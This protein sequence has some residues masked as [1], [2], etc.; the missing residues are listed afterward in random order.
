M[1][2]KA[3]RQLP[4]PRRKDAVQMFR[5]VSTLCV[6]MLVLSLLLSSCVSTFR[7]S[8]QFSDLDE[9]R[10]KRFNEEFMGTKYVWGGTSKSGVD[11]S[12]FTSLAYQD[13][14]VILPRTSSQQY[15]IGKPVSSSDLQ[16]GDLLFFNT[17]GRGVSHVGI[18]VEPGKMVHASTSQGVTRT[19]F[20]S[21]Y[22][23]KRYIGARR[24][25]GSRFT[26]GELPDER[27]LISSYYPMTVRSLV[28]TP[29]PYTQLHRHYTLEFMT[30]RLG[31]LQFETQFGLWNRLEI[32]AQATFEQVLGEGDFSVDMPTLSVK[33]RL[34]EEKKYFPALAVGWS[35]YQMRKILADS[36]D[37]GDLETFG[38][39]RGFYLAA[40]KTVFPSRNWLLGDQQAYLGIGSKYLKGEDAKN[41]LYAY[42]GLKQAFLSRL[43][44]MAEIDDIFRGGSYSTGLRL[45]FNKDAGIEFSMTNLFKEET[46]ADRS[47]RF[48]YQLGY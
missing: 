28:S 35:N 25:S 38:E 14:G 12:G 20:P 8:G 45:A 15:E 31:N 6:R 34:L 43:I 23:K 10:L 39:Q 11:C 22:W 30:N 16:T 3:L 29:T 21:D 37:S 4:G 19:D 32:G 41:E 26:Q 24:I 5:K 46:Q 44:F 17:T 47:L 48:I 36:T 27:I 1:E 13:Q 18:Y 42:L 33:L 2:V 40:A 9:Q 7:G